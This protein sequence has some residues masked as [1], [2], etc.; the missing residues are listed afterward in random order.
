MS[1]LSVDIELSADET[2][3]LDAYIDEHCLDREKWLKRML[4]GILYQAVGRWKQPRGKVA[5]AFNA[6]KA[7]G[8]KPSKAVVKRGKK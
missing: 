5:A 7:F 4:Y 2:K 6:E 3:L 1:A 8:P